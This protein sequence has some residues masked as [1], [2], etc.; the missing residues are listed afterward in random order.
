MYSFTIKP[1]EKMLPSGLGITVILSNSGGSFAVYYLLS[2]SLL[3]S[4]SLDN[5]CLSLEALKPRNAL[6]N[7]C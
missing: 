1:L 4:I 5:G 7:K 6:S 3:S 2:I